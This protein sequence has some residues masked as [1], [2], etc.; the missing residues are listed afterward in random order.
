MVFPWLLMGQQTLPMLLGCSYL[1]GFEMM[2][3]LASVNGLNKTKVENIF[4]EDKKNPNS[5]QPEVES[6]K[7]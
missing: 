5:R 4:E 6:T 3:K 7:M 1:T 2:D